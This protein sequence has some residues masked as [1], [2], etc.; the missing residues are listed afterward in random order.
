M[1]MQNDLELRQEYDNKKS[2]YENLQKEVKFIIDQKVKEKNIPYENIDGRIKSLESLQDKVVRNEYT[3]PFEEV[4]DICGI[5]VICLFPSDMHRISEIIENT[6]SVIEKDDKIATKPLDSFGYPSIHYIAT[7]PEFYSGPRYEHI[8]GIKFEIQLRTIAAHAWCTISHHID[9][10]HP[11]AVPSKL[12]KPFQALS[13]LFYLADENFER[14]Y[15]ASA[16]AKKAAEDKDFNQ[17]AEDEINFDSLTAYLKKRYPNQEMAPPQP[18]SLLAAEL[19]RAGYQTIFELDR[20]LK[21]TDQAVE[22]VE[23]D[24]GGKFHNVGMVRNALSI[25]D[26]NF[27]NKRISPLRHNHVDRSR[28]RN[29]IEES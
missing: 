25:I 3:E 26:E 14:L 28:Y 13:A 2:L 19:N 24:V 18:M 8:M 7:L 20:K 17:I 29:Y 12:Q 1:E 22:K 21:N 10:K 6:F 23:A 9:Y 4:N 5:R 16:E 15:K 11:N 27:N